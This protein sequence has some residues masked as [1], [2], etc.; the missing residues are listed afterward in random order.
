DDQCSVC[1]CVLL[2]KDTSIFG[3]HAMRN[4]EFLKEKNRHMP[5][6]KRLNKDQ[7]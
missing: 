1:I 7:A 3:Y 5:E 4:K 2:E 6:N